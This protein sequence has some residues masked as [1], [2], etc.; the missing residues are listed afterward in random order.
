[1]GPEFTELKGLVR[2]EGLHTRLR[3]RGVPTF[4]ECWED[5]QATLLIGG[6]QCTRRCVVYDCDQQPA[7]PELAPVNGQVVVATS[8]WPPP[9]T[10]SRPRTAPEVGRSERCRQVFT[11]H[12]G[13]S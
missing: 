5:R 10:F 7:R 9:R 8:T 1:M 13:S 6:D 12:C 2:R 3:R 11:V 4:Y